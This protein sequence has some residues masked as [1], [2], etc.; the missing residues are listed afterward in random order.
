MDSGGK[1]RLWK[2]SVVWVTINGTMKGEKKLSRLT[3]LE[4]ARRMVDSVVDMLSL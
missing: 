3:D 4:R 1:G 2:G